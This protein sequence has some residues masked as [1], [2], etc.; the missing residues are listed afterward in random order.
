[1]IFLNSN[2]AEMHCIW[3]WDST[4]EFQHLYMG[5]N[6]AIHEFTQNIVFLYQQM[7]G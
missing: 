4:A 3:S 6:Y 2:L 7:F 1:M 5:K